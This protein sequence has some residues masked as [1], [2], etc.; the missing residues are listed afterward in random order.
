MPGGIMV[1]GVRD[2]EGSVAVA[3]P[4]VGQ[5]SSLGEVAAA[6]AGARALAKSRAVLV[7]E[8][9][10]EGGVSSFGCRIRGGRA[11]SF[12]VSIHQQAT[13]SEGQDLFEWI[14]R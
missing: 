4:L 13:R 12:A 3:E 2:G 7:T 14:E 1:S 9:G 8:L 5:L 11:S 6:A 10:V